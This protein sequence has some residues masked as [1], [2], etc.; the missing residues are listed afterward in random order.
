MN[1]GQS[2]GRGKEDKYS[3]EFRENKKKE[4]EEWKQKKKEKEESI[5]QEIENKRQREIEAKNGRQREEQEWRSHKLRQYQIQKE[6]TDEQK[7]EME[8]LERKRR[9]L[10]TQQDQITKE[11]I[12]KREEDQ[13]RRRAELVINKRCVEEEQQMRLERAKFLIAESKYDKVESKLNHQT[14]AAKGKF[15]EKFKEGVDDKKDA[16]TF[17]YKLTGPSLRAQPVWRKGL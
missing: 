4:I 9:R 7:K 10:K 15:R 6:L 12:F 5:R 8:Q 13:F 2:A 3:K 1:R 14:K 17:G 16:M 11:R